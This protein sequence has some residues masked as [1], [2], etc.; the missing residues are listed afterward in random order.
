MGA[1]QPQRPLGVAWRCWLVL[2]LA[3]YA[4]LIATCASAVTAALW[5]GRG[6][7]RPVALLLLG[8]YGL[9]AWALWRWAGQAAPMAPPTR[10]GRHVLMALAHSAVGA[11][12]GWM[13]WTR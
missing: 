10:P 2:L 11:W 13:V 1:V 6:V 8:L 3:G 5:Q 12:L 9:E 7:A 4:A